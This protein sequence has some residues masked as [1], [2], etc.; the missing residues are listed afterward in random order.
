MCT[1]RRVT[2]SIRWPNVGALFALL[3][4][5]SALPARARETPRTADQL[6][7][8]G[9]ALIKAGKYAQACEKLA[10]SLNLDRAMG[11]LLNLADCY[12][13]DGKTATAL[14]TFEE[15]AR[16]AEQAK[17]KVRHKIATQRIAK[18]SAQVDRLRV[19]VEE[20]APQL[21]V[22]VNGSVLAPEL[23]GA[24][25]P[26]D[27]QTYRIRATAPDREDYEATV[28]VERAGRILTI[29]VPKLET[30]TPAIASPTTPAIPP[31]APSAAPL[32]LKSPARPP[33]SAPSSSALRT[34][35]YAT[36]GV[37]VASLAASGAFGIHANVQWAKT[38]GQCDANRFCS[39]QG[40]AL[41]NSAMQS[42]NWATY[43]LIAGG[44]VTATGGVMWIVDR[45]TD[46]PVTVSASPAVAG[47][48]AGV[49]VFG[50]F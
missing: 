24:A 42:G 9:R 23:W 36:M 12:E 29:V 34:A 41:A 49:N 28:D 46:T 38:R 44:A 25:V 48:G 7:R 40:V 35:S 13:K 3:L 11:T 14:K 30:P 32:E 5:M 21:Q 39:A 47:N 16:W 15:V 19:N 50:Q 27:P 1:D 26:V 43:L 45:V 17:E 37:G 18:L 4:V 33:M 31:P 2:L 10:A 22:T 8:E 20:P 6:F